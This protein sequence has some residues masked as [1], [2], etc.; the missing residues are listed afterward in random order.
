MPLG[1]IDKATKKYM[2]DNHNF[3]DIFNY[4]IFGGESV[5]HPDQL[6]ELDPTEIESLYVDENGTASMVEKNRDVLKEITAKSDDYATY[7]LMGI[8]NQTNVDYGMP[9]R[10]ML[11]DALSYTKQIEEIKKQHKEDKNYGNK[12]GEF[13][14]GIHKDDRLNPV[15]TLVVF[16]APEKWDGPRSLHDMLTDV[17]PEF[18]KYIADYQINIVAP[19]EL[20]NDD[21]KKFHSD[22]GNALFFMKYSKDSEKLKEFI[23][24]NPAF[25]NVSNET[26]ELLNTLTNSNIEIDPG[27]ETVDVCQAIVDLENK[28]AENAT[29]NTREEM[30]IDLLKDGTLSI[31]KISEIA[32]I[33]VSKVQELSN[34]IK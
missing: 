31:E 1:D 34:S 13:I 22:V 23:N 17:R 14:S 24:S 10:N 15:I 6:Q 21:Y 19:E 8:E 20:E 16:W 33:P 27:K 32:K 29:K 3:A 26:V 11:Y 4:V 18:L 30:V 2:S 12:H 7:V 25:H 9:V 28:A 5:I